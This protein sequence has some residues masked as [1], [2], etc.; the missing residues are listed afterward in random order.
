[1]DRH[2]FGS[3]IPACVLKIRDD[4]LKNIVLH[5]ETLTAYARYLVHTKGMSQVQTKVL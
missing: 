2:T 3:D 1:M 4:V 5:N